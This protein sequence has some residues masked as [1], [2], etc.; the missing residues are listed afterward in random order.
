[1]RKERAM[2]HKNLLSEE[3]KKKGFADEEARDTTWG[4]VVRQNL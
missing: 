4:A 3:E 1:M 2:G